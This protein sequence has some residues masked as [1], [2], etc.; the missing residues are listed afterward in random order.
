FHVIKIFYHFWHA[1]RNNT[2]ALILNYKGGQT[3]SAHQERP[4][5]FPGVFRQP[6]TPITG[7]IPIF[8]PEMNTGC[9]LL[10]KK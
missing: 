10:N 8:I 5:C 7:S 3:P 9:N 6:L 1:S 2:F 4:G